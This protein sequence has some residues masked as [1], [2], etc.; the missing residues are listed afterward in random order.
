[1]DIKE[2]E[3][4]QKLVIVILNYEAY[5]ETEKCIKSIFDKKVLCD[6]IV[7]VD[8][9]SKNDSVL[10]LSRLYKN[11]SKVTIVKNKQN[12][13][14]A[15]GNNLGIRYARK[16]MGAD[17]VLLLNSD[18]VMLQ[19]DYCEKLL[20]SYDKNVAV[21]QSNALRTNG[22]YT[23]KSYETYSVSGLICKFLNLVCD[24]YDVYFP[25]KYGKKEEIGP[26]ISGC[27]FLLTPYFF[28]E[29]N[30]LYPLTFL[31]MEEKILM[32]M[33]YR[34]Q[35]KICIV[36]EA[37]LLHKE[38]MS[39]PSDLKIGQKRRKKMECM[40]HFHAILVRVMPLS[41][42]RMIIDKGK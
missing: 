24:T 41:I 19:N 40:G 35:L 29:F 39:T 12:V 22:R 32:I 33:L 2:R 21:I 18:T 8:N 15:R 5:W 13:G 42:I 16:K 34:V 20:Q 27:D 7:V 9:G 3:L 14:F 10:Y 36:E 17:F 30:G 26:H 37:C 11:N 4:K 25:W 38:S 28:K 1:M 6:G 23:A 31:F